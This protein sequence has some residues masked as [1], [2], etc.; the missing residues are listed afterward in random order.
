MKCKESFLI[1]SQREMDYLVD[2]AKPRLSRTRYPN[3]DFQSADYKSDFKFNTNKR[4][5][6]HK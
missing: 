3:S 6:I 5:I 4:R 1:F 2:Y